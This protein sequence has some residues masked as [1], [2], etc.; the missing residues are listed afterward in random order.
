MC[1]PYNYLRLTDRINHQEMEWGF[2]AEPFKAQKA[3]DLVR[4][5]PAL[6]LCAV[7]SNA[8]CTHTGLCTSA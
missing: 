8:R 3:I 2:L 4:R 6:C 7:I 5:R 1:A